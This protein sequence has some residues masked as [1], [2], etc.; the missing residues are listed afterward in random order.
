MN[1]YAYQIQGALENAQGK[2]LG[3]RVLVCDVNNF[4]IVDVPV[5]V[6]DKQTATYIQFR[7]KVTEVIDIQRLPYGIQNRIRAP[8]GR[9]LDQWVLDNFYGNSSKPKSTNT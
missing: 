9:W 2:F 6:L 5:E 1:D 4:E 8:L 3:L 7:L